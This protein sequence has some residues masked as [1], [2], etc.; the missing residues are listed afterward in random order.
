MNRPCANA[1]TATLRRC[2]TTS[3]AAWDIEST[4]ARGA[5]PDSVDG[6]RVGCD[7]RCIS[8]LGRPGNRRKL[9]TER[10][11]AANS[12]SKRARNR[13]RPS[14]GVFILACRTAQSSRPA[15]W[16]SPHRFTIQ[17]RPP[18][19]PARGA[20]TTP[21]R[22][23]ILRRRARRWSQLGC[24]VLSIGEPER[25]QLA[26]RRSP[27]LA[28]DAASIALAVDAL[29]VRA[30]PERGAP[31]TTQRHLLLPR[32]DG[33]AAREALGVVVARRV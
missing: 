17:Q 16:L 3:V 4:N 26:G 8:A 13:M 24:P 27:D 14:I 21:S 7:V 23:R 5:R 1:S 25:E 9:T 31:R 20:S 18:P 2:G 28:G 32:R 10:P 15:R 30:P 19:S 33:A 22:T 11:W 12:A 29:V 6:P